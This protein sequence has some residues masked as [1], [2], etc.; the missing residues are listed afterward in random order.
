MRVDRRPVPRARVGA[1]RSHFGV[2][3]IYAAPF[4]FSMESSNPAHFTD[5]FMIFAN[6]GRVPESIFPWLSI[7][8]MT[9][10]P[11]RI[12]ADGSMVAV[13]VGGRV[14]VFR[15]GAR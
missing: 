10:V 9:N 4:W 3:S 7:E 2:L 6:E 14:Q 1:D 15:V 5:E 12:S 11:P 13:L 8:A